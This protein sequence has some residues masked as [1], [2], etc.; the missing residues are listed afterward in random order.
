MQLVFLFYLFF[1]APSSLATVV[2]ESLL[3]I[4]EMAAISSEG[5]LICSKQPSIFLQTTMCQAPL[6]AICCWP[7][8]LGSCSKTERAGVACCFNKKNKKEEEEG[9]G[10]GEGRGMGGEPDALI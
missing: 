5:E 6:K 4:T 2:P 10:V 8:S 9:E 7:V 1:R 3:C